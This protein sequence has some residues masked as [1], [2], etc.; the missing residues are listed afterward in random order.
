[1]KNQKMTL[2]QK[3]DKLRNMPNVSIRVDNSTHYTFAFQKGGEALVYIKGKK[4]KVK[5]PG[6]LLY[7][8][9]GEKEDFF[10]ELESLSGEREKPIFL[11]GIKIY[12]AIW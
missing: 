9:A 12:P 2:E 4:F 7:A 8:L 11:T 5:Y 6:T 10:L 3:A 1:M